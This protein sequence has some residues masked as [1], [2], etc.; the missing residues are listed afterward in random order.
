M[1]VKTS[2]LKGAALD[3]VVAECEGFLQHVAAAIVILD[4]FKPS[5]DWSQGGPIIEREKLQPSYQE[6]GKYQGLWACNK[7]VTNRDGATVAIRYYGSTLLIA[8]MQCYV[9][10]KL[11]NE[12]EIPE[13]LK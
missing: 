8:A 4:T 3:W 1:K 12:V 7:W 5:S 11:G 10:C 13:E 2:E 6:H 9:A